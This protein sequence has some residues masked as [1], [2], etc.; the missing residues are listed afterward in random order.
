MFEE[1]SSIKPRR[2]VTTLSSSPISP[3]ERA[4]DE[5][6]QSVSPSSL[7][8]SS[9]AERDDCERQQLIPAALASL[10]SGVLTYQGLMLLI[11][12]W[13][14]A[15]P[16]AIVSVAIHWTVSRFLIR[17][18]SKGSP[19]ERRR[20]LA[21]LVL[22]S[23]A[24]VALTS[25][26]LAVFFT[27]TP[28]ARKMEQAEITDQAT[29]VVQEI[30]ERRNEETSLVPLVQGLKKRHEAPEGKRK[31]G[32]LNSDMK[33]LSR[34]LGEAE[35]ALEE[36]QS[37]SA[38]A[39]QE[40]DGILQEMRYIT[41]T[42]GSGREVMEGST[43]RFS[44]QLLALNE[45]LDR[46]QA[47]PTENALRLVRSGVAQQRHM[48]VMGKTAAVRKRRQKGADAAAAM[49]ADSLTEFEAAVEELD[50]E[51]VEV[52]AF[53]L[54]QPLAL[55]KQ[56]WDSLLWVISLC[57]AVDFLVPAVSVISLA[58]LT[59]R[60]RRRSSERQVQEANVVALPAPKEDEA[61]EGETE[62]QRRILARRHAAATG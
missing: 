44:G 9:L 57:F 53:A 61:D 8:S 54:M 5:R 39:L 24:T 22:P 18:Y 11:G 1:P 19:P 6:Q 29:A 32:R 59:D 25:T 51:P 4:D 7:F 13:A 58:Y 26:S 48:P 45:V 17:H 30:K 23:A 43:Q 27:A 31:R 60:L 62:L 56:Y 46:A 3:A 37:R 21:T 2:T 16:L 12:A 35:T 38:A 14:Q 36:G 15:L 50:R 40:A 42:A 20:L 28:L 49:A 52:P 41:S 55:L 10:T 33:A 34:S 47:S